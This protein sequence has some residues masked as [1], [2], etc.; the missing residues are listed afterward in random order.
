MSEERHDWRNSAVVAF[1]EEMEG[2][3]LAAGLKEQRP[4]LFGL[5]PPCERKWLE[6]KAW[7]EKLEVLW[8]KAQHLREMFGSEKA[9]YSRR[10]CLHSEADCEC[11]HANPERM[12]AL[13]RICWDNKFAKYNRWQRRY[14]YGVWQCK[15]KFGEKREYLFNRH[16]Q[17]FLERS[18]GGMVTPINPDD[19]ERIEFE[20]EGWFYSGENN[21][22]DCVRTQR[23]LVRVLEAFHGNEDVWQFVEKENTPKKGLEVVR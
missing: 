6:G 21:P 1:C 8:G 3:L 4:D 22:Q 13:E 15:N 10:A 14:P 16:Y 11:S 18:Y 7:K 17:P 12:E 19:D 9:Q 5:L 20:R 23:L 2:I